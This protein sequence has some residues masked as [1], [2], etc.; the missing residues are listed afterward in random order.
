M[1]KIFTAAGISFRVWFYTSLFLVAVSAVI[2][3]SGDSHA[4]IIPFMTTEFIISMLGSIP[5]LTAMF[6]VM[7]LLKLISVKR[8]TRLLLFV[9]LQ[10]FIALSYGFAAELFDSYLFR[11]KTFAAVSVLLFLCSL[12]ATLILL[13]RIMCFFSDG[14][15]FPAS[16]SEAFF[17]V[18]KKN[19]PIIKMEQSTMQVPA[20]AHSNRLLIKGLITGGLILLLIIPTIFMQNLVTERAQRQQQIVKE[21]SSRWASPQ[22]LSGPFLTVPYTETFMDTDNKTVSRKTQLIITADHLL[23]NGKIIPEQRQ[24]S[25]YKVLLY[26]TALNFS[27]AFKPEWPAGINPANVDASNAKLC[28]ALTDFKGIEDEVSIN[29]NNK[30]L[31]LTPGL[32]LSDAGETGLSVPV[33]LTAEE[34]AGG[35]PF[36]MQLKLKGSE[37]LY[38]LPLAANSK[39]VLSSTWADP[40]FDGNALPAERTVKDSG[41]VSAWN[42]SRANLAFGSVIKEGMLKTAN[43]SFGVSL[44]QPSDQYNKTMRSVK[45]A[46]LIIGLSFALF[47]IIE[48]MQ[49]KPMHPVQY[50]LAGLA[51]VIFYALLLSIS[52]FILF[53]YAYLIASAATVLLISFYTKAHFKNSGPALVLGS[54]LSALYGFVFILISLEDTALLVGSIGLFVIL[55][56]VMYVSRK[57]NWYGEKNNNAVPVNDTEHV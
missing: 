37:Q 28:F 16:F 9:L 12:S 14:E 25:I 49:K 15:F 13:K 19:K 10:F 21:V 7:P 1:N 44:L 39:F 47:F 26:R 36:D 24:R 31:L 5:A 42:F 2:I 43:M 33:N 40:S 51:M 11:G 57:I 38:F 50:L 48:I 27:G 34:M 41:F 4:G 53:D 8:N 32:P 6:I 18:F 22:T 35:I 54:L 55:A 20:P 23:M 46:V 3:L 30:K 52:E 45:Y 56:L 29:F 17:S